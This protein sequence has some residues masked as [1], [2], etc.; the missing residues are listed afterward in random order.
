[1]RLSPMIRPVALDQAS[2]RSARMTRTTSSNERQLAIALALLALE[3]CPDGRA[4][5]RPPA[6]RFPGTP[7]IRRP[8]TAR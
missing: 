1:M 2:V 6:C 3:Q 8:S 7:A 5:A 4:N